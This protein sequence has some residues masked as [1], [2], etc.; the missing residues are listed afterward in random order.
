MLIFNKLTLKDLPF[1][2]RYFNTFPDRI[3]DRSVGCLFMWREYFDN[4]IAVIEDT[5]I[6]QAVFPDGTVYYSYPIGYHVDNALTTLQEYCLNHQLP[7]QFCVVTEQQLDH[8]KTRF[9]NLE[10]NADPVWYDYYY[11]SASLLQ[12]AGRKYAGQRNHIHKFTKLYPNFSFE[13]I[14]DSSILS[15]L[16]FLHIYHFHTQKQG[17]N[18]IREKK[19]DFEFMENYHLYNELGGVL[20]ADGKIIGFS[21]GEIISDTIFIHIEKADTN[22][23]GAYPMLTNQFL[24][25]FLTDDVKFVNREE[26]MGDEGLRISKSSY[27]PVELIKKY[28]VEVKF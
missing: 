23:E 20:K 10:A 7:L 17:D 8:L 22:Y 3:C 27:H 4:S 19:M 25:M 6:L 15:I 13:K 28:M 18:A 9:A 1:V 24:K 21:V 12:L 26:D 5:I 14:T 2:S 11:E 16:D